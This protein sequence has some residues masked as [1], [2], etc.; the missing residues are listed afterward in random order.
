M[1]QI[2]INSKIYTSTFKKFSR[3]NAYKKN[4][5]WKSPLIFLALMLTFA[6]ICFAFVGKKQGALLLGIVLSV[7]GI[8]LPIV[9]I[10]QFESSIRKQAK[11]MKLDDGKEAYVLILSD[12]EVIIKSGANVKKAE[13]QKCSWN[14][15]KEVWLNAGDIYLYTNKGNAYI[16]PEQD[17][18][19]WEFVSSKIKE[20]HI[21]K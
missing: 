17:E 21:V 10:A 9:Y 6:A 18:T 13:L 16:L 1:N 5:I 2:T 11:I 3:F 12:D 8:I 20:A 14:D 15:F 7:I 19:T 4:K